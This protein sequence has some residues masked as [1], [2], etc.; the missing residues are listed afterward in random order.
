MPFNCSQ[1]RRQPHLLLSKSA[2]P[3]L[4]LSSSLLGLL[5]SGCGGSSSS[6]SPGITSDPIIGT[7]LAHYTYTDLGFF[8]QTGTMPLGINQAGVITG[9]FNSGGGPTIQSFRHTGASPATAADAL[10]PPANLVAANRALEAAGINAVG[11]VAGA[12]DT[13]YSNTGTVATV[14]D[15][16][17]YDTA[18]HDLG[19]LPPGSFT[20]VSRA[21]ATA[22]NDSGTV[23]GYDIFETPGQAHAFRHTGTGP[24]TA[25]D[26]LGAFS[27][28]PNVKPQAVNQSG[29]VAGTASNGGS[30]GVNTLVTHAFVYDT[31]YHDL[32]VLP[33]TTSSSAVGINAHGVVI[34]LCGGTAGY[35]SFRHSGTG[36]LVAADALGAGF[37]ATAINTGGD[38]VGLV[39]VTASIARAGSPVQSLAP[40]V[41]NLPAGFGLQHATA[42]NDAGQIVGYTEIGGGAHA[43]LLTPAP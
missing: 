18:F 9:L 17:V 34:G 15:A 6:S 35:N 25:A 28:Y 26:D 16:F 37:A 8:G 31:S 24:L 20:G 32:G 33:G 23:V 4:A 13:D 11:T 10:T 40:L 7:P 22:I 41:T 2:F 42:I 19:A 39:D 29:T 21:A 38:V 12:F 14:Q 5:L 36:P 1:L 3:L 30:T 43:W 27:G